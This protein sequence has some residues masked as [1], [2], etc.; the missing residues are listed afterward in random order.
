MHEI[1]SRAHLTIIAAAGDRSSYGL[2]GV[3]TKQRLLVECVT[4]DNITV[5]RMLP[6]T[7]AQIFRT[8][9]AE[10]GW[11][12]QECY[13]SP[14]RLIFTDHEVSYLCNAMHRAETVKKPRDLSNAETK[15][16]INTFQEIIPSQLTL[17]RVVVPGRFNHTRWDNLKNKQLPNYT[18]RNLTNTS[19]SIN[20]ALGL[21]RALETSAIRHLHGIPIHRASVNSSHQIELSLAWHHEEIAKRCLPFPSWS[22]SGWR[23]G[24]QMSEPDI[25]DSDV[26]EIALVDEDGNTLPLHD[27]FDNEMR[28]PNSSSTSAP[29]VLRISA[30]TVWL[31]FEERNW[32]E[33][34]G[35]SGSQS[36]I[37]GMEYRNGTYAVLPISEEVTA[38]SYVYLDEH[39][40]LD[41]GALGLVLSSKPRRYSIL[42]VRQNGDHH[43]QRIG[44]IRV[45]AFQQTRPAAVGNFDPS[46]IY[47][48]DKGEVLTECVG[49]DGSPRW[50]RGGA[51]R[52]ITIS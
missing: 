32:D 52:S 26:E 51:K 45:A 43:Y 47:V 10:R 21:F 22:W 48:D 16:D 17:R 1:Y 14:R 12:Y 39:V 4:I 30:T 36:R 25:R 20:A 44:L 31:K 15:N 29:Y 8:K 24:I 9:W 34:N 46:I 35:E 38:L 40:P 42:L 6:H 5:I 37:E 19:D 33:L 7:L 41:A 27:W 11:I 28:N 18:R 3:G 13:L 23:G 50:L 2:P 49:S